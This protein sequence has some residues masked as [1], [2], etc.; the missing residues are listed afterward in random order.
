MSTDPRTILDS[1]APPPDTTVRYGED[2]D[3]IADLR[4][5]APGHAPRPLVIVIH[6]G[7]WRAEWDR[8]HTGPLAADLAARGYPVAQL[9]YRRTGRPGGGWPGTFA[10]IVAGVTSLPSLAGRNSTP[11]ILLGHSAG[12]HLA[13]WYAVAGPTPVLGVVALAPVADLAEAHRLDLDRGAVAA[14]LGGGPADVPDRYAE[15]D[16]AVRTPPT[17]RSVII[18]GTLDRHVPIQISRRYVTGARAAGGDVTLVELP[19]AEHFAPID[20]QSSAWPAVT[21]ALQSLHA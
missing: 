2:P 1:P 16:P 3:Q 5:P 12:G 19:E 14:L 11:P 8:A 6:G 15:A 20:P 9:E 7:F 21:S 13:L 17:A 4:L 10:D 18:H